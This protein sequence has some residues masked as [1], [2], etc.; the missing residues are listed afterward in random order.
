MKAEDHILAWVNQFKQ[1][2]AVERMVIWIALGEELAKTSAKEMVDHLGDCMHESVSKPDELVG[3]ERLA[4]VLYE[5][6]EKMKHLHMADTVQATNANTQILKDM[7][8]VEAIK[9]WTIKLGD[10]E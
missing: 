3:V 6:V 2:S 1:C 5:A 7:E 8:T 10:E 9:P 4:V